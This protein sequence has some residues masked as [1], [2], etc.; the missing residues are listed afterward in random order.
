[1]KPSCKVIPVFAND[2]L[3]VSND[4]RGMFVGFGDL[5]EVPDVIE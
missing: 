5:E 3:T 4:P 2:I 1:M